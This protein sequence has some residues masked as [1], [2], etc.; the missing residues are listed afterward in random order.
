MLMVIF[1]MGIQSSGTAAWVV[2]SA[3]LDVAHGGMDVQEAQPSRPQPS[4]GGTGCSD[5][6]DPPLTAVNLLLVY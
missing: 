4:L 2:F 6:A 1:L 3:T 5:M